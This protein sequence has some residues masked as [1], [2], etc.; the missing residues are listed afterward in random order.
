MTL[1][2][3][4]PELF[5]KL[6]ELAQFSLD[7]AE[8]E[9]LRGEL[10]H[11]LAAVKELSE[12]LIDESIAP[13]THGLEVDGALPRADEWKLYPDPASIV[14]LAPESEE[15]LIAVP[16]VAVNRKAAK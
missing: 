8:S 10:N 7:P 12:I 15:G 11:Q 2:K 16:D 5:E 9:Y 14:A 3:I 6:V 1:E 4:T 13:T